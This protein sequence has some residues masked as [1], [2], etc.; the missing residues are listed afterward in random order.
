M[1]AEGR[2]AETVVNDMS[3]LVGFFF[4][5]LFCF[6][7]NSCTKES[8]F[9]K[10]KL[11]RENVLYKYDQ[12]G[13]AQ[14]TVGSATTPRLEVLNRFLPQIISFSADVI[15]QIKPNLKSIKAGLLGAAPGRVHRPHRRGGG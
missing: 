1:N 9:R 10:G 7:V 6:F 15:N 4:F 5:C 8:H 2:C 14:I 13:K 3:T 11:N 12:C